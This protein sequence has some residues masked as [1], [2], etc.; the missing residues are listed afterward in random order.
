MVHSFPPNDIADYGEKVYK[1]MH[2]LFAT[3]TIP[4]IRDESAEG[5]FVGMYFDEI[6]AA[7]L[8][9]AKHY[10]IPEEDSDL[11]RIIN[12]YDSLLKASA[13]AMFQYGVNCAVQSDKQKSN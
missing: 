10:S 6:Y 7:R 4:G 5:G 11:L 3:G 8:S 12:A 1:Q 2:G 13:I 9:L